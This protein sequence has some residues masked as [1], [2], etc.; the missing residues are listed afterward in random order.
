MVQRIEIGHGHDQDGAG[1]ID[2][3]P[4]NGGGLGLG[5]FRDV[6]CPV[7][8]RDDRKNGNGNNDADRRL[9]H[10]DGQVDTI[11]SFH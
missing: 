8:F 1:R 11:T 6:I 10:R 5:Q 7:C 4:G 2:L 3:G 9:I